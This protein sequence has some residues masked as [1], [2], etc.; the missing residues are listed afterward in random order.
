MAQNATNADSGQLSTGYT[1]PQL[2]PQLAN[3][4]EFLQGLE[5][6]LQPMYAQGASQQ[7]VDDVT[8]RAQAFFLAQQQQQRF[9]SDRQQNEQ[10]AITSTPSQ[11]EP[12]QSR[13]SS[14]AD[15][16]SP[17]T[18]TSKSDDAPYPVSFQQLAALIASGAP[19]PGLKEI[20]DKL[21]EGEPSESTI[22]VKT[23]RKPWE[24]KQEQAVEPPLGL[25]SLSRHGGQVAEDSNVSRIE[26]AKDRNAEEGTGQV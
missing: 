8:E 20:P 15:A 19:I 2:Y 16:A 25:G 21:A 11:L 3:N 6:I 17:T 5:T 14:A 13:A 9:A 1:K 4:A 23:V 18:T 12:T 26:A 24:Q 22:D 7:E 10:A